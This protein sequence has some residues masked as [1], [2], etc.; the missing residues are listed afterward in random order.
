ML[1][2]MGTAVARAIKQTL[3]NMLQRQ[4]GVWVPPD[5]IAGRHFGGF[6]GYE[7][8]EQD[9]IRCACEAARG[10]GPDELSEITAIAGWVGPAIDPLVPVSSILL[11]N[12]LVPPEPV[13]SQAEVHLSFWKHSDAIAKLKE[14][15]QRA[16][17]LTDHPGTLDTK[18]TEQYNRVQGSRELGSLIVISLNFTE[19]ARL[20]RL[21]S[22]VSAWNPASVEEARTVPRQKYLGVG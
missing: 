22:C 4:S 3:G 8:W 12:E 5:Y 13:P 2:Q 11:T 14:F 15:V 20:G 9:C 1:I 7:S 17:E 18:C 19:W 6:K 21:M 10:V 16:S